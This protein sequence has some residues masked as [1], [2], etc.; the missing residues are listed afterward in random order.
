MNLA[1]VVAWLRSPAVARWKKLLGLA[2]VA[3]VALPLDVV[4]DVVP[5]LGWL[6]DLGVVAA[7]LAF[8]SREVKRHA[9]RLPPAEVVL[10]GE[11]LAR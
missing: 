11:A 8:L 5:V 7:T 1:H 10:E 3:Y 4:P 9:A 2:A 6:D